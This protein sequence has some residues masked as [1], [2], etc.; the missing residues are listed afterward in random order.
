M[1]VAP[2]D[3]KTKSKTSAAPR[4][5]RLRPCQLE[6]AKSAS[7]RELTPR[8]RETLHL[9]AEGH[10]TKEIAYSLGVSVK[11]VETH[12]AQLKE[13]LGIYNVAGLVRYALRI[14]LISVG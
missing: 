5:R 3:Q 6:K 12:R 14:G 10:S 1:R 11:T 7:P 8:Q 2:S 13:R 4:R 9:I